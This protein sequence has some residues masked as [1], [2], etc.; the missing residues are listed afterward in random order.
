MVDIF[1]KP[2]V[3]FPFFC[4]ELGLSLESVATTVNPDK[5]VPGFDSVQYGE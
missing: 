4:N 1:T 5:D 3:F 2:L